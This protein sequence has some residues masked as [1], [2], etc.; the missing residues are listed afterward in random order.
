MNS[1]KSLIVGYADIKVGKKGK[2]INEDI[3]TYYEK[4]VPKIFEGKVDIIVFDNE[5]IK[6]I[7]ESFELFNTYDKIL[8]TGRQ[9]LDYILLSSEELADL[10]DELED[11]ELD[12][13][14][15]AED[16]EDD[17]EVGDDSVKKE[18]KLDILRYHGIAN[19]NPALKFKRIEVLYSLMYYTAKDLVNVFRFDV[20][21]KCDLNDM[22]P[23]MVEIDAKFHHISEMKHIVE[24]VWNSDEELGYDI[25]SFKFPYEH[26][27]RPLGFSL[28]NDKYQAYF[29]FSRDND[30]YKQELAEVYD[31]LKEYLRINEDKLWVFNN[32]MENNAYS[33][34]FNYKAFFQDSRIFN[35]MLKTRGTLKFSAN[36]FLGVKM[37]T[38]DIYK[39]MSAYREYVKW[40]DSEDSKVLIK[41]SELILT[42]ETV[43]EATENIRVAGNS[44][45]NL[46]N[47]V[48]SSSM[49]EVVE[50]VVQPK[51]EDS[52]LLVNEYLTPKM[53]LDNPFMLMIALSKMDNEW[54]KLLLNYEDR[55]EGKLDPTK[56]V[57]YY[58]KGYNDWQM[59][60][61][62][63]MGYYCILD[64]YYTLKIKEMIYDT[65]YHGC[66]DGYEFYWTQSNFAG[67]MEASKIKVDMERYDKWKEWQLKDRLK[68]ARLIANYPAIVDNYVDAVA[69]KKLSAEVNNQIDLIL[70]GY[71]G[72]KRVVNRITSLVKNLENVN[73][74]DLYDSYND[75]RKANVKKLVEAKQTSTKKLGKRDTDKIRMTGFTD[76]EKALDFLIDLIDKKIKIGL[77]ENTEASEKGTTVKSVLSKIL[78]DAR[79]NAKK[80]INVDEFRDSYLKIVNDENSTYEDLD[81]LLDFNSTKPDTRLKFITNAMLP[82][83]MEDLVL[84]YFIID[85]LKMGNYD[86]TKLDEF[87][88]LK[89]EEINSWIV[90][91]VNSID[92]KKWLNKEE[93]IVLG[94]IQWSN[95]Y[96]KGMKSGKKFGKMPFRHIKRS[97][98]SYNEKYDQIDDY[99]DHMKLVFWF[100]KLKRSIKSVSTVINGSLGGGSFV[101]VKDPLHPVEDL[102]GEHKFFKTKY[103]NNDKDTLRWSSAYHTIPSELDYSLCLVPRSEN[104][105]F[106]HKDLAQAEVRITFAVAKE[107]KVIDAIL[108]GL[109]IHSFNANNAFDLG[110]KEDELYK[111]KENPET[112]IMRDYAKMITFAVLYG[113]GSGSLSSQMK[114]SKEEGQ[115]IIDGYY[116]ANPNFKAYIENTQKTLKED[117]GFMW[118]PIFNHYFYIGNPFHYSIKQKGLNYQ[119]QNL[120]S[121]ICAHCSYKLYR[122]LRDNHG[123]DLDFDGF[124]HDAV[125]MDFDAKHL[126]TILDRIDYWDRVYPLEKWNIPANYDCEMGIDKFSGEELHYEYNEDKTEATMVHEIVD[127]YGDTKDKFISIIE[128]SFDV[129]E[130]N[131]EL[132]GERKPIP[133]QFQFDSSKPHCYYN[134]ENLN[135]YKYTARI[136]LAS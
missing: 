12:E 71:N 11:E 5:T 80:I 22:V 66:K 46:Y 3:K 35:Q 124:I 119:I 60:G 130:S 34:I 128:N 85:R 78:N 125:E 55:L 107:Q 101:T 98:E 20:M 48:K 118:L 65:N 63:D 7:P 103:W 121:S 41:S 32:K 126:F 131:V 58:Q 81:R 76:Q 29:Y 112:S 135:K 96:L 38:E 39:V 134:S 91:F 14:D 54:S 17:E 95:N 115:K 104:R 18:S 8:V 93:K 49:Y 116:E 43:K 88:S 19:N 82:P 73:F 92:G 40:M 53:V 26:G 59:C 105:L 122:D 21:N 69:G 100:Q 120:S 109:D 31:Y 16:D 83:F 133:F 23:K 90:D 67:M 99:P 15:E 13:D 136:R 64:S 9:P 57:E 84:R 117:L 1:G 50:T 62:G 132:V 4:F 77:I 79:L 129:I 47:T 127:F 97:W 102:S 113:A 106:I 33:H 6:N 108:G 56:L 74:K 44:L 111:V 61:I 25:E 52:K 42:K 70:L 110:F 36:L 114:K 89:V 45:T 30:L 28:V 75:K 24:T 68:F 37:W 27:F 87:I 94:A 51:S 86:Q 2:I 10:E 123:I 72:K